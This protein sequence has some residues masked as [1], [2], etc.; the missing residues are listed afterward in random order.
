V[1]AVAEI[2]GALAVV[3]TLLYLAKQ[4]SHAVDSSSSA[5]TDRILRGF[6]EINRMIVSDENLR[7]TLLKESE[8]TAS[9]SEQYFQ[10]VVLYCN[11]WLSTQTEYD[12]GQISKDLYRAATADV[13]VEIDR[14]PRF[15]EF[16]ELWL[17]RYPQVST[18]AIFEPL[19]KTLA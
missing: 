16:G 14:W 12:R 8:L 6:D 4:L 9:E 10:F 17:A 11:I 18:E 15:K 5:A 2:L 13:Q 19:R 1:G 3:A 7:A